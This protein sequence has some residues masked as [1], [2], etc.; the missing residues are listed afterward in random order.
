MNNKTLSI[1]VTALMTAV[2]CILGPNSLPIGPVPV[3]LTNLAI[4]FILYILDTKRA[5]IAY[6]LYM[7]LGL[8]GLPVFSG[9]TGGPQ[10]LFGPTGGYIIGFLPM[11]IIIGLFLEKYR[12]NRL[13]SI[14]VMEAATWI[15][16]LL[17]TGWLALTAHMSFSAALMVGVVPFIF[18]DLLKMVLAALVGPV[19]REQIDASGL[20]AQLR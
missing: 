6:L 12:K 8:A 3:S 16:Y 14:V 5:A 17:G 10:K 1:T 11:I 7:L 2:L 19:L 20:L 4:Y 9:F 15:P 18:L 13:A